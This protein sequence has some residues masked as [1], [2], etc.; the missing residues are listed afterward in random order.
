MKLVIEI[1]E[2]IYKTLKEVSNI[3]YGFR[4]GKTFV[5]ACLTA[6]KNGIPLPKGHGRL[7]DADAVLEDPIG[8]T[9]K[10]IEIAETIIEADNESEAANL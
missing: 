3:V 1:S 8:N 2:D 10:D 9:Y 7:I 6:I 4:S 5:H